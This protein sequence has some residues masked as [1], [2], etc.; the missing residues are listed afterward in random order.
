MIVVQTTLDKGSEKDDM[1]LYQWYYKVRIA[2]HS[3]GLSHLWYI[4]HAKRRAQALFLHRWEHV[5]QRHH[6]ILPDA[7]PDRVQFPGRKAIHRAY[8]QPG[9]L[10]YKARFRI[11]RVIRH[12]ERGKDRQEAIRPR[13]FNRLIK[14]TDGQRVLHTTN[15]LR[16]RE[17]TEHAFKYQT[18][19]GLFKIAELAA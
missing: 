10:S 11:Q 4:Y 5:R 1:T 19:Q 7:L 12:C 17:T 16:V 13:T 8:W 2:S 15:F 14:G 3:E 6:R 18:F 9:T